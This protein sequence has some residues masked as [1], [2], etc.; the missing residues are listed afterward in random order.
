V[1]L[2][3]L[4]FP[5]LAL[6]AIAT[7]ITAAAQWRRAPRILANLAICAA[8]YI[9][10]V[11]GVT[12]ASMPKVFHVGEPQ[13]LDDWCFQVDDVNRASDRYKVTIGIFSRAKRA[14][15]RENG[16][17]DVYLVDNHWNRYDPAPS[18]NEP[19]LNTLLQPG[20]SVT[21]HRTFRV[22]S[23]ARNIGLALDHS[24]DGFP[25]C[26]VIGECGAFHK[27]PVIRF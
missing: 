13:C 8:L 9:G 6:A 11:Y 17:K 7:L 20:E 18:P 26:L 16:A 15:Q 10:I 2:F 21:T 22:P 27:T 24:N 3:D 19:P 23:S 14:A 5:V 25:I 4:L 12:A 1:T